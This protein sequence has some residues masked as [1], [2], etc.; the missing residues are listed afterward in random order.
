VNTVNTDE[1]FAQTLSEWLGEEAAHRVPN[2][3][4]EV[5]V[6]TAATR[7]RPWWS[8]LER[9]IPMTTLTSGRVLARPPAFWF[10]LITLLTVAAVGAALLIGALVEKPAPLGPPSNG[11][12]IVADGTTLVSYAADGTDRRELLQT[13]AGAASLSISPDGTRVAYTRPTMPPSV[14][15]VSVADGSSTQIKVLGADALAEEP[16]GWSPDGKSLV[17]AGVKGAKEQLFVAAADGSSVST[18]VDGQL[19]PGQGV[20]QPTYSPDGEWIAFAAPDPTTGSGSLRVVHP[21]GTGLRD[22]AT[23]WPVEAGDGGGPVWSPAVGAHRIAY[24]TM[25]DG[26]V[27]RVFD[28]DT[29]TDQVIGHGFWPSWSPDGARLATCCATVVDIDDA[30]AGHPST[31][32]VFG[33]FPGDCPESAAAWTGR[34]ICS[35]V[36]WSPDGEWLI[37]AD[38]AGNDLLVARA[39]GTSEPRRIDLSSVNGLSGFR[40]PVTWQPV[41]P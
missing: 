21:D 34:S 4:A 41:W 37:A 5:L 15:V 31:E 22:I 9:L 30:L 25:A 27:T 6:Q 40:L 14:E 7:Q 20:F 23:T 13:V 28:L 1:R 19:K 12:I 29:D 24:L 26:L 3:L 18:P 10:A 32:T 11:R 17:F 38:I 36:V 2:H 16:V 35:A 39:D 33:Q 8:S